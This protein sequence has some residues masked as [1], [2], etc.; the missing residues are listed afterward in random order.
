MRPLFPKLR[1]TRPLVFIDVET[2]SLSP[3]LARVIELAALKLAPDGD[4]PRMF[5]ARMN[6]G[7]PIPPAATRVHGITDADVAAKPRFLSIAR[8]FAAFLEGSDLSGFNLV[9]FDLPIL[10]A[11][12]RRAVVPFRLAG[13]SV[14]D[15]REIVKKMEPRTLTAAL[16]NYVGRE[17]RRAHSAAADALATAEV[18][19]AMVGR[20]TDLPADASG[21]HRRFIEVDVARRFRREATGEIVFGFGKFVGVPLQDVA[22]SAPGYLRWLLTTDLL[23]D[24]RDCVHLALGEELSGPIPPEGSEGGPS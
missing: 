17:H 19:N 5:R 6:P 18:L 8:H 11:E 24:A 9:H 3:S 7:V 4:R 13:R 2:T 20:Y 21:L 15:V 10:A 23:E 12:F 1:L 14:V 16:R 22:D